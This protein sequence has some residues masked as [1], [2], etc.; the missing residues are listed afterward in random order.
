[1]LSNKLQLGTEH[2]MYEL[3]STEYA[4]NV[5]ICNTYN[6][7]YIYSTKITSLTC[8]IQWDVLSK[9]AMA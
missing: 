8:H 1:M 3:N 4:L 2:I 7:I 5:P 9:L 6:N